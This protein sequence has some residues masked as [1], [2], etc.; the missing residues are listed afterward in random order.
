LVALERWEEAKQALDPVVVDAADTWPDQSAYRTEIFALYGIV[1]YKLNDITEAEP[2]LRTA[3]ERDSTR[4]DLLVPLAYCAMNRSDYQ[5]ARKYL[6]S[7]AKTASKDR[8]WLVLKS[9][10]MLVRASAAD[11]E[12]YARTAVQ[13]FP[14]DPVALASLILSLQKSMDANKQKEGADLARS[15]LDM[16]AQ[17]SPPTV[18]LDAAL[19][20]WSN[21]IAL[22]FFITESYVQQDWASAMRYLY[23]AQNLLDT[24][25]F[26]KAM[27]ATILRKSGDIQA[28][29]Q[30]SSNWYAKEPSNE[31]AAEAYLRSL[32]LLHQEASND[33]LRSTVRAY[34]DDAAV[35]KSLSKSFKSFLYYIAGT[36]EQDEDKAIDLFIHSLIARADNVEAFIALTQ[37]YLDRY[38]RQADKHNVENRDTASF[39]LRQAKINNPADNEL[40]AQIQALDEQLAML[41]ASSP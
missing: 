3:Y 4:V 31:H 8:M 6:D 15:L 2:Y 28:A 25:V 10:Y 11:A 21:A 39:Y 19:W 7:A 26:D 18:P 35:E 34:L 13:S 16:I 36:L 20:Q 9:Q 33:L 23:E 22:Q 32:A 27:I 1:R 41:G 14:N 17:N 5:N 37:I 24:G 40:K 38:N 29:V 30:F 12:R